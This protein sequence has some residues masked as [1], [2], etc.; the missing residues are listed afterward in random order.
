[1][2]DSDS[3]NVYHDAY[4]SS[5][6]PREWKVQELT[7]GFVA[8]GESREEAVQRFRN[9]WNDRAPIRFI[10]GPPPRPKREDAVGE[11]ALALGRCY[12]RWTQRLEVSARDGMVE[13]LSAAAA[14]DELFELATK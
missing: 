3:S 13:L 11:R 5:V 7:T 14:L 1:V 9:M 8:P 4:V 12:E 10:D 6:L 2:T